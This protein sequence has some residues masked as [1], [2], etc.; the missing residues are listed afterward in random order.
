MSEEI[1]QENEE[2]IEEVACPRLKTIVDML[3]EIELPDSIAERFE[4]QLSKITQRMLR[5]HFSVERA[6]VTMV[7]RAERAGRKVERKAT[8]RANLAKALAKLQLEME[9]LDEAED[10]QDSDGV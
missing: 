8:R 6:I 5:L 10:E 1:K 7:K 9:K 2:A 3:T 4:P